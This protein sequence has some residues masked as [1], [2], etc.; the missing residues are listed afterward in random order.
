[1]GHRAHLRYAPGQRHAEKPSI[2]TF[3][4]FMPKIRASSVQ[5][6]PAITAIYAHHVLNGTGTFE[7]LPPTAEDMA[8]R[9]A[10]V[11]AKELPYLVAEAAAWRLVVEQ[12]PRGGVHAVG[13]AVV[14][15]HVVARQL[16][17]HDDS[18]AGSH[19]DR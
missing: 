17:R 6:I 1:M 5:D 7:T 2:I 9:R 3:S 19:T 13:L 15:R 14:D 4:G 12:N 16:K 10:E 8:G 18:Q 11:L